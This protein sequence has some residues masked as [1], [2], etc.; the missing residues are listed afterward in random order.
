[1]SRFI[2]GTKMSRITISVHK[3]VEEKIKEIQY[4]LYKVDKKPYSTSKVINMVLVAGII[5]SPKLSVYDW[6]VIKSLITEKKINL[7]E[8]GSEEYATNLLSLA[9]I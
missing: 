5:G 8:I 7:K 3:E 1:M 4:N 6:A 9:S 2:V